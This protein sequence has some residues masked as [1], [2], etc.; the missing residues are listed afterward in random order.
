MTAAAQHHSLRLGAAVRICALI[1]LLAPALWT[2]DAPALLALLSIGVVWVLGELAEARPGSPALLT[3]ALEPAL[4]GVVC[5]L[6]LPTSTVVLGALAVGPVTAGL[7]R[8]GRGATLAVSAELATVL[9]VGVAA[10]GLLSQQQARDLVSWSVVA[11][12]LGMIATFLH[13]A[14]RRDPD[15]LAAYHD[16][17]D[18]IRRLIELSDDLSSGL[19]PA[20]MATAV[21]DRVRDELPTTALA[22][23]VPQGTTLTPLAAQPATGTP[24]LRRAEELALSAWADGRS[25]TA[26]R[27]FAFPLTTRGVA[28][29]VVAGQLSHRLD[30]TRIG[31]A[32]RVR[33]LSVRLGPA[34]VRL[35]TALLFETLRDRATA[36]ER[37]RLAREIHDGLAQDIASLGYLVDALRAEPTSSE[38]AARIEALRTRITAVVAEV[39]RSVVALRTGVSDSA[40]LGAALGAVARALSESSGVPVHVTIDERQTRLRPEVEAELFRIAQEAMT[41]AVRHSGATTIDVHCRVQPPR[42]V[43]TVQDDGTGL[44]P[45]RPDSQGLE[46]MRERATLIGAGLDIAPRRPR[47]TTVTVRL[48][49]SAPQPVDQREETIS[50]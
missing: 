41:N 3:T 34:A 35:D 33:E 48:P 1:A 43:I 42:A 18:L 14:L 24:E 6:T 19:D 5:G 7:R 45:L 40:S 26:D 17:Q 38:Q 13:S 11:I 8:G 25:I 30:L 28:V 21:L 22:L 9:A 20:A 46:I 32:D 4:V 50:A 44:G 23:L 27:A 15:P 2:Q 29:G 12:G 47:G 39:R 10:G 49:A 31:L 36:T 37:R 16:A